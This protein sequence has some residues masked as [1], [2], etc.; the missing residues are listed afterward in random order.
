MAMRAGGALSAV[1]PFEMNQ[2]DSLVGSIPFY[3]RYFVRTQ[4]SPVQIAET[5]KGLL[6]IGDSMMANSS[7]SIYAVTQAKNHNLNVLNG[8]LYVSADPILGAGNGNNA[9]F[10]AS[11]TTQVGD[12]LISG[13]YCARSIIAAHGAAGAIV[14]DWAVGGSLNKNIGAAIKR[15]AAV[16]LPLHGIIW[17]AG[18]NDG[19]LGT[20]QADYTTGLAS[21]IATIRKY[22]AVPI[23]IGVTS[24]RSGIT[25]SAVTSAQAAAVN[26]TAGIYAGVNSDAY[27]PATYIQPDGTHLSDIGSAAIAADYIPLLHAAGAI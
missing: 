23:L 2:T 8:G 27:N 26:S 25:Y 11:P 22:A 1:D 3:N 14:A 9:T 20:T 21:V 4:V 18:P 10:I 12:L 16:G 24:R 13:G 15:F 6:F 5:I 7:P 17:H 19:N